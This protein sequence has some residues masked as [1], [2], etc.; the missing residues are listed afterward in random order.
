MPVPAWPK[1]WFMANNG[2]LYVPGRPMPISSPRTISQTGWKA[3][4]FGGRLACTR[5][6]LA[7]ER[8]L[9]RLWPAVGFFGFYLALALTGVFAF[10]PWPVQSLLLAA[11]ITASALSLYNGFSDFAWPQSLD[12]ARRLERDSG[13]AHRPISERHDV[14]V[15]GDPFARALWSLHKARGLPGRFRVALPRTGIAE[16]DPQGLRWYLLVA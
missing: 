15:G 9:P 12:A 8:V 1:S 13:F 6:V 7:A 16:R 11:T 10:I 5:V 3:D 14:L 2:T 4:P